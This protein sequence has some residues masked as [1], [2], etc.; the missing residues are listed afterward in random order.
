MSYQLFHTS[1][2][3]YIK[4][5]SFIHC[6]G[7]Q[8]SS[9]FVEVRGQLYAI[10]SRTP[11]GWSQG[12]NSSQQAWWQLS[13]SLSHVVGPYDT[14]FKNHVCV[15]GLIQVCPWEK[16]NLCLS[17]IY[18]ASHNNLQLH[19]FSKKDIISLFMFK[20]TPSGAMVS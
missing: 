7:L 15:H 17:L 8:S 5:S 14:L 6:M 19:S 20:V 2:L 1:F 9:A 18:F 13:S 16:H 3:Q 11:Q 12:S 4:I 10:T